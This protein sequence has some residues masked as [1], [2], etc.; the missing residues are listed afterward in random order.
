MILRG[1][2]KFIIVVAIAALVGAGLGVGLAS[3]TGNG[4]SSTPAATATVAS[5]TTPSTPTVARTTTTAPPTR[6]AS[7]P[8]PRIR[9]ISARLT[10]PSGASSGAQLTV[11]VRVTNRFNGALNQATPVLISGTD[12]AALD[13]GARSAAST[14]LGTLARGAS[15]TGTLRFTLTAA[16]AQTLRT[17]GHA[18]LQVAGRAVVLQVP[19][20]PG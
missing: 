2:G 3:L 16:A 6:V 17:T 18:R 14:L 4:D 5:A 1:F 15:A 19:T 10:S 9:V 8:V 7:G 12:R 20:P 11:R 13:S